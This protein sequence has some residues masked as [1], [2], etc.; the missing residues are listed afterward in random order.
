MSLVNPEDIRAV[1]V[2]GHDWMGSR[3]AR[4]QWPLS[5]ATADPQRRSHLLCPSDS[6]LADQSTSSFLAEGMM[7]T[8]VM[9]AIVRVEVFLLLRPGGRAGFIL[10]RAQ[11]MR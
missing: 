9:E 7:R 5:G 6:P 3:L 8:E 4:W 2:D 10:H 11:V 1:V